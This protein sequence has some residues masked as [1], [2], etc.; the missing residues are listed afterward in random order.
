MICK[1]NDDSQ[2]MPRK[3]NLSFF[4]SQTGPRYLAFQMIPTKRPC[5]TDLLFRSPSER[6]KTVYAAH[7]E[8]GINHHKP[9]MIPQKN[10]KKNGKSFNPSAH[11][12][13][14][15]FHEPRSLFITTSTTNPVSY[16]TQRSAHGATTTLQ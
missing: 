4:S 3:E 14:P 1:K 13:A 9:K 10:K 7:L 15:I 12:K 11:P 5:R 16:T 2:R 8:I 6:K